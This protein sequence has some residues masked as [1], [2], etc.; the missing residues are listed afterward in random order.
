MTDHVREQILA[1]VAT[2]V[3]S[4]STTGS[5]V[6]RSRVTPLASTELPALVVKMGPEARLPNETTF[7]QPRQHTRSMTVE[8]I[9]VVRETDGFETELNQIVAEVEPVLAMPTAIANLHSITL[10]GIG[11]PLAVQG[12]QQL[13]A[14]TMTY[15]VVYATRENAPTVAQ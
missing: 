8:V 12:E 1:A 3:T 7:G 6:Y 15:E 13:A 4:L 5:H 9:V 11:K 14:M 2:A 10:D